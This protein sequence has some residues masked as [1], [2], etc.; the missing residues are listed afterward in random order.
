MSA[1]GLI[2]G[3]GLRAPFIFD[4][5]VCT[6]YNA[7]IMRL[8][9][10]LRDAEGPGPFSNLSYSPLAGR[11]LVNLSLAVNYHFGQFDPFG[12]H[13]VNMV[14]HAL[15]AV[16]LWAIVRRVLLLDYFADKFQRVAAPLALAV[17]LVWAV[18]PLLTDAVE[19]MTQRTELMMGWCYLATIYCS[20]RYFASTAP[21]G[22]AMWLLLA[23]LVCTAG[24]ACKEVM[25]S[26]PVAVLLLDRTFIAGSFGNAWRRSW[27]LYLGL[28]ASW[29]LLFALNYGGPR[30]ESAGFHLE[31][32]AY[33]W[34]FTQTKVLLMY[35][36]LVV[37]PWP[38][39][40]HYDM[41]YLDTIGAAW[42]YLAP[43]AALGV[44]TLYLLWRGTATGFLASMVFLILSPTLV[45][46]ITT[47]IAAERRMYLPLA[48][49]VSLLVV[50]GYAAVQRGADFFAARRGRA[51]SGWWPLAT[52]GG[53]TLTV[54]LALSLLSVRRLAA[55][56]DELTMW[57]DAAIYQPDNELVLDNFGL[58]L[59]QVGR[60]QE[61]IAHYEGVLDRL[62]N[63][64]KAH[65]NYGVALAAAGRFS[66]AIEHHER[67]VQLEPRF[68][69]AQNNWGGT[70]LMMGQ[71]DGFREGQIDEVIAHEREAI[72]INPT[73]VDAYYNLGLA[74]LLADRP[75]DAIKAFS[76]GL[77]LSPRSGNA[78][79]G[80]GIALDTLGNRSDAET[81]KRRSLADDPEYAEALDNLGRL[82]IKH[83][84]LDEV[85]QQFASGLQLDHKLARAHNAYANLLAHRADSLRAAER[86]AAARS[87]YRLAAQRYAAAVQLQP[88]FPQALK[89]LGAVL[90]NLDE[91]DEAIHCFQEAVRQSPA[92]VEAKN[93]LDRALQAKQGR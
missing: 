40:I 70:L 66:E 72:R 11:P 12:Y 20:L 91:T 8:Y 37:W 55:Y 24:M 26:A 85:F 67:A 60:I 14:L 42:P 19:Y 57:Q 29:L 7:S 6:E 71:R 59:I 5:S 13:V 15:S 84:K 63:S 10:L 1:V 43:V 46:P 35:L 68:G 56:A 53:C 48:A 4:D 64:F 22:R 77:A 86:D 51:S 54:A 17:A 61:A 47:E 80:I 74:M 28:S 76:Q 39:V 73:N 65:T 36:K 88:N 16:L 27:P 9:P 21:P 32:P 44:G 52:L 3:R 41:P 93:N 50:G 87:D 90:M 49:L 82:L 45:V 33:A 38:M 75:E 34:W 30:S 23:S 78:W 2:Y 92:D 89:K 58:A 18:H 69:K 31:V 79:Q 25:V 62:P 83:I 81:K